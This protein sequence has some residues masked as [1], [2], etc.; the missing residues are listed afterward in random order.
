MGGGAAIILIS[1][2]CRVLLDIDR[3]WFIVAVTLGLCM[4]VAGKFF[5]HPGDDGKNGG[6]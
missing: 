2:W 5:V 1:C 6:A 3:S 4:V